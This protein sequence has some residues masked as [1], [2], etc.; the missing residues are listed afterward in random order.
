MKKVSEIV[1]ERGVKEENMVEQSWFMIDV[2]GDGTHGTVEGKTY[3]YIE[4]T[5]DVTSKSGTKYAKG[6]WF[7]VEPR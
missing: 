7:L 4:A 3:R 5:K 6:A 2:T 1:K